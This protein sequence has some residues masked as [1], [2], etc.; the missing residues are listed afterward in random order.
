M[1]KFPILLA[2]Q[3]YHWQLKDIE[4]YNLSSIS[5]H[6]AQGQKPDT[7]SAHVCIYLR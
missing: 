4:P 7:N 6:F 3:I 5:K 2:T 1:K